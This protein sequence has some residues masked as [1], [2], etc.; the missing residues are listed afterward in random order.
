MGLCSL[1]SPDSSSSCF[2]SITTFLERSDSQRPE[3]S[4]IKCHRRVFCPVDHVV[5]NERPKLQLCIGGWGGIKPLSFPFVATVSATDAFWESKR[6]QPLRVSGGLSAADSW[7]CG[8]AGR[9]RLD[10]RPYKYKTE[11][12][13]QRASALTRKRISK[14]WRCSA[15]PSAT[16]NLR[17]EAM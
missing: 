12:S 5:L 11:A 1:S 2:P 14:Q 13:C 3:E 10:L 4:A 17:V 9:A 6:H 8:L 15:A 16:E 7:L